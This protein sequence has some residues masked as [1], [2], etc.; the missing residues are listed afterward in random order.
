F[1]KVLDKR[2]DGFW[3]AQS[4]IELRKWTSVVVSNQMRD[5]LRRQRRYRDLDEVLRPL[6]EERQAFFRQKTGMTFSSQVADVLAAGPRD[7]GP[8]RQAH[9]W[10]LRHRFV[11]GMP[12]DRIA[13]QMN[14]SIHAVRKLLDDAIVALRAAI[15]D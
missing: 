11:D 15:A 8:A 9:A 6:I 14:L 2:P 10:V 1:V 4:A 13:D 12:R 7:A 3:R 5:Y